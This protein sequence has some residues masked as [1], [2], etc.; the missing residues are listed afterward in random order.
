M[1]QSYEFFVGLGGVGG[2]AL[3]EIRRVI[4]Q[5]QA[6]GEKLS[7]AEH[8]KW[9]YFDTN[10][11]IIHSSWC[12]ENISLLPS[13][14]LIAD[15]YRALNGRHISDYTEMMPWLGGMEDSYSELREGEHEMSG[16][17]ASGQLRRYARLLFAL[18]AQNIRNRLRAAI[19]RLPE[20]QQKGIHFRLFASLGGGT[21]S[22]C[23]VDMISLIQ[24]LAA[25]MQIQ[26][27]IYVYPFVTAYE[28]SGADCGYFYQNQFATLRDL[29]ALMTDHYHP[30]LTVKDGADDDAETSS[31]QTFAT[32]RQVCISDDSKFDGL[33]D[34]LQHVAKATF[35]SIMYTSVYGE[36]DSMG[37]KSFL[38]ED[39]LDTP[40]EAPLRSRR[41]AFM[42]QREMAMP[43]LDFS[44]SARWESQLGPEVERFIKFLLPGGGDEPLTPCL[45][46][47]S[48]EMRRRGVL[49]GMPT[50]S[51]QTEL[52]QW[53][54]QR[55]EYAVQC[56]LGEVPC[57]VYRTEDTNTIRVLYYQHG[58]TDSCVN[59]AAALRERYRKTA[60][61]EAEKDRHVL[62]FA[63][64]DDAGIPLES[65]ERPSLLN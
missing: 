16:L 50:C 6:E 51:S 54:A 29:N 38:G 2:R 57:I 20:A 17:Y 41:F 43:V 19:D 25:Q 12:E 8:W 47:S 15:A 22:G 46:R 26:A 31:C 42:A 36:A 33:R 55:M 35:D 10:D 32:V 39:L 34:E 3:M 27:E 7:G 40:G 48:A 21:G 64:L 5:H 58:A 60:E 53:L 49:I 44:D 62:Y 23:L 63:N 18:H 1:S 59:V 45:L 56:F 52:S 9:L 37:V 28:G 30:L 11:D 65:P 13:E 24:S 14:V 61:S 4:Q